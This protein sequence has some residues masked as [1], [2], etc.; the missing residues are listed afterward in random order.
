MRMFAQ[1]AKQM[2]Q[3]SSF[4]EANRT[5]TKNWWKFL[6][7][8]ALFLACAFIFFM[9]ARAKIK[10]YFVL[11]SQYSAQITNVEQMLA[12]NSVGSMNEMTE[13]L[14]ILGPLAKQVSFF[15]F[16]IVPLVIF[17]LWCIFQ[18]PQYS[19]ILRNK[20]LI[21]TNYIRFVV[22][23]APFY[24]AGL[25]LLNELFDIAYASFSAMLSARFILLFLLLIL[26]LYVNQIFYAFTLKDRYREI[27]KSLMCVVKRSHIMFPCYLL[28]AIAWMLALAGMV[29][30][31][32]KWAAPDVGGMLT[33]AI[34]VLVALL[35][36]GWARAFF[37]I[38]AA[39]CA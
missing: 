27:A 11:I 5:F 1:R 32:L 29:N 9:Y 7:L 13:L 17:A 26:V 8:D 19:L 37:T 10:A 12:Q 14:A 30:F 36:A 31:F 16:F 15:T 18:A 20:L 25:F 35:F 21:V 22:F 34:P 6:L 4:S 28:Y 38:K 39:R 3:K 2:K 24:V 33:A 23:A